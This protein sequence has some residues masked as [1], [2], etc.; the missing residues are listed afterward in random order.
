[1]NL[2]RTMPIQLLIPYLVPNLY[3]LHALAPP[4]PNALFPPSLNLTQASLEAHGCYLLEDGQTLSIWVGR[5]VVPQLCVDLFG[6]KGYTEIQNGKATLP[7]LDTAISKRT[8]GLIHTLRAVRRGNYYP[9]VYIVK[10]DSDPLTR[11]RFLG[12]LLEDRTDTMHS[13]QQFL[14]FMKD[15]VNYVTS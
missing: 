1:M 9:V 12:R 15:K 4:A 6:V 7:V 5:G 8:H 11:S 2:L 13:Y 14:Q 3:A 10:E